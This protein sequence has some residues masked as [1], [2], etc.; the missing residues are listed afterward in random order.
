MHAQCMHRETDGIHTGEDGGSKVEG[1]LAFCGEGL[2][3]EIPPKPALS[4]TLD[5]YEAAMIL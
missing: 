1:S 2:C 4:T 3:L 5:G